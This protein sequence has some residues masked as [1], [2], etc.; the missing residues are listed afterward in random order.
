MRGKIET[1]TLLKVILALVVIWLA[2]EI[3]EAFVNTLQMV[4]QLLPVLLGLALVVL[5][6]LYLKDRL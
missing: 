4:F 2:L 6:V 5:I 1:G 3:L